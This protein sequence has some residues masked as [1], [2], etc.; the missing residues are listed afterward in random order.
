M[1]LWDQRY[2][3][4]DYVY[5]RDPNDF[6]RQWGLQ[7]P[8]GRVLCLADG[9]GRN[10]VW[11]AE[12]GYEVVAVDQ[13]AVG[14][15]KAA[16][17]AQ[18]RGVR[19]QTV[20][21]NLKD[22]LIE[23]QSWQGVVSIFC[24]LP[25]PLWDQVHQAAVHGLVPGGIFLLEAYSPEQLRLQPIT[26]SGGPKDP[27]LLVSLDQLHNLQGITWQIAETKERTLQEGK[28]HQGLAAVIQGLGVK[29]DDETASFNQV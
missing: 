13:S 26:N 28:L 2:S 15:A 16:R 7:I 3:D 17:L 29:T 25:R 14:L 21:A 6:L 11:L 9:E 22:F 20:Q 8:K 4:P 18:E 23:P 12:Q 24:H 19:V 1:N 10:G 5:G 27:H